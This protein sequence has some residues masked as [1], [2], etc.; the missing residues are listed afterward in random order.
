MCWQL[1]GEKLEE[2]GKQ[3]GISKYSTVSSV[4]EKV[5]RDLSAHRKLRLRVKNIEKTL[6]N[7]QQQILTPLLTP[8]KNIH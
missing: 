6:Y 7:S 2:I 3:F 8:L 5:K 4:I 1:R